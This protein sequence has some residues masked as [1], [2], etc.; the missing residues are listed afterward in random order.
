MENNIKKEYDSLKETGMF[1]ELFYSLTGNWEEDKE[2][3]TAFVNNRNKSVFEK[4]N[5]KIMESEVKEKYQ[6]ILKNYNI[7]KL[8]KLKGNW[9]DDKERFIQFYNSPKETNKEWRKQC[10][11]HYEQ[12]GLKILN[13]KYGK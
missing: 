2:A 6:E 1:W 5:K 8:L 9:E 10:I 12:K 13:N 3:F 11:E 4:H 7:I